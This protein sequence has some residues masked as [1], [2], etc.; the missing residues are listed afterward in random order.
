MD[1]NLPI[2]SNLQCLIQKPPKSTSFIFSAAAYHRLQGFTY[3]NINV[4]NCVKEWCSK[5]MKSVY[6][7][8]TIHSIRHTES[9]A[10]KDAALKELHVNL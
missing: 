3:Q 1:S 9:T 8:S 10:R 5:G 7:H 6:E 2:V 4:V